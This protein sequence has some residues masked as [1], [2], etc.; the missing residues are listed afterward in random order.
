M[1]NNRT[2]RKVEMYSW[3]TRKKWG[4]GKATFVGQVQL[5]LKMLFFLIASRPNLNELRL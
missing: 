1:N 4:E 3:V 2:Q 5:H